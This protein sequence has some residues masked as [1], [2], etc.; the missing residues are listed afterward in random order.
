MIKHF[1]AVDV[2]DS[3]YR[4][5]VDSR[6]SAKNADKRTIPFIRIYAPPLVWSPSIPRRSITQAT[7]REFTFAAR[8]R[9]IVHRILHLGLVLSPNPPSRL[10]KQD[11]RANAKSDKTGDGDW[12]DSRTTHRCS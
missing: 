1:I 6:Q 9:R 7:Q 10:R 8:I 11:G 5:G 2:D 4:L 12:D 3:L